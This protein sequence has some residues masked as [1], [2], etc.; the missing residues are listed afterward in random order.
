MGMKV[1][2]HSDN[3]GRCAAFLFW[4]HLEESA[5]ASWLGDEPDGEMTT[6]RVS[7]D[8]FIEMDYDKRI[9]LEIIEEGEDV[10]FLDFHPEDPGDYSWLRTMTNLT[11]IDHHI[12]AIENISKWENSIGFKTKAT[13]VLDS[14]WCGAMLVW[15]TYFPGNEPPL[16]LNLVDD[17]DCW[18]HQIPTTKWFN[19]GT[20]AEDTTPF[21]GMWEILYYEHFHKE[22]RVYLLRTIT[23][24]GTT[25]LA[26]QQQTAK[27]LCSSIGFETEFEGHR[28]FAL[29]QSRCN[30]TWFESVPGYDIYLPFNFN[31]KTWTV[32]LYSTSTDVSKIAQKHGG[33]GHK[34]AAGFVCDQL[35]FRRAD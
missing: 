27:E 21:G 12:T 28:C 29:N 10:F 5:A 17:W 30:S 35:P 34:G 24:K 32:S 26:V 14:S 6:L 13:H 25:V 4:K 8:D 23:D 11:I 1:F 31:G 20:R 18:K 3:D 16:F 22:D 33:G 2:H 9:P 7:K 15:W 19:A